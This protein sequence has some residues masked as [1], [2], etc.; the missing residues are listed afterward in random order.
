MLT[1]KICIEDVKTVAR[2]PIPRMFEKSKLLYYCAVESQTA[3]WGSAF[4]ILV[5]YSHRLVN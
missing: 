5:S 1:L 2:T 3:R 4:A